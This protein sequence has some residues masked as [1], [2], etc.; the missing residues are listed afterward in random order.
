MSRWRSSTKPVSR[1][2]S[3][4]FRSL[5][6]I[7]RWSH[8]RSPQMVV[9][10]GQVQLDSLVITI[11]RFINRSSSICF[12]KKIGWFFVFV[13]RND[14]VQVDQAPKNV[15]D[16]AVRV[17]CSTDKK[18]V[19]DKVDYTIPNAIASSSNNCWETFHTFA[20]ALKPLVFFM[21]TLFN[22]KASHS[23]QVSIQRFPYGFIFWFSY[24]TTYWSRLCRSEL[25]RFF[26]FEF[27]LLCGT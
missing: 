6:Q 26:E 10:L 17:T 9:S 14:S 25:F 7:N 21:G 19:S 8:S 1:K 18:V 16:I 3:Y 5:A 15:N 22:F 11:V 12:K 27:G 23:E 2:I 13:I 20:L 4:H 24:L